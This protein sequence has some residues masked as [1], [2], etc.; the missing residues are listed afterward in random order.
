MLVSHSFVVKLVKKEK[1][2]PY[3]GQ[4]VHEFSEDDL[5]RRLEFCEILM[6]M[7]CDENSNF[8]S[9]VSSIFGRGKV[10]FKWY[11]KPT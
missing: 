10:L 5:D 7:H 6:T 9:R 11:C 8:L 3:K 2:H 1:L 4:L